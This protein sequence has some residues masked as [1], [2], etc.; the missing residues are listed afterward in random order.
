MR[1][2]GRLVEPYILVKSARCLALHAETL[3]RKCTITTITILFLSF[4]FAGDV[5][6]TFTRG[7]RPREILSLVLWLLGHARTFSV[8]PKPKGF[9]I[10]PE[11]ESDE[12]RNE[13][14]NENRKRGRDTRADELI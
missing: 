1:P 12:A 9:I 10:E 7:R 4:G 14:V 6:S 3:I 8:G 11:S 5:I 13:I 2:D